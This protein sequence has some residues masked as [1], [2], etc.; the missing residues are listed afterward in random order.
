[1]APAEYPLLET[2][3]YEAIHL[4]PGAQ[5]PPREVLYAPGIYAY[6]DRFGSKPE[7]FCLVAGADGQVVG[8]AWV[9]VARSFG[10]VDDETPELA[11][12]VLPGWRGQGVGTALLKR[13]LEELARRGVRQTSLSVQKTNPAAR[14]YRR[15]GY[16]V[17][18]ANEGGY[19]MLRRL[20]ETE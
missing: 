19:I 3:L 7:D 5:P 8:A 20:S 4:P 1:M 18:R 11:V 13:L 17:I 10:Y 15:L 2:F 6:I 16:E 12:S 14:L 9:R